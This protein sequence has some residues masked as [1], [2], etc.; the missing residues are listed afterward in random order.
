M[1][2]ISNVKS[3]EECMNIGGKKWSDKQ[4]CRANKM[5]KCKKIGM[6]EKQ[7]E[8]MER[9]CKLWSKYPDHKGKANKCN[10]DP[11]KKTWSGTASFGPNTPTTRARPTSAIGIPERKHGAGL[12][13][14]VQIPRPQGQGQQVQL[15]S[16]KENMERDCKLW[17]KYP[18]HKGKAN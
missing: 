5:I 4:G 14:L 3:E 2:A 6:D 16:Q 17:S 12:Q 9:D 13:A 11:R 10:W 18:D 8:N 15:G 1:E 7:K